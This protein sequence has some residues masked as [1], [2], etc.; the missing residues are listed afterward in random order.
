MYVHKLRDFRRS[1][2]EVLAQNVRNQFPIHA[3]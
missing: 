1:V 3:A 2:N